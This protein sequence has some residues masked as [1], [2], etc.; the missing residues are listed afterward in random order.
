MSTVFIDP[1]RDGTAVFELNGMTHLFENW[2]AAVAESRRLGL[3]CKVGRFPPPPI[4]V[5]EPAT[6]TA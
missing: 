3:A 1:Q 2:A 4:Q 5:L 6:A